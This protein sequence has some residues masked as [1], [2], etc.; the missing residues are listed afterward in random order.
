MLNHEGSAALS[1][2][3]PR[4]TGIAQIGELPWGARVCQF[5][6]T[7]EDLLEVHAKYFAA[8]LADHELCIWAVS[9]PLSR[10]AAIKGLSR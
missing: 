2:R 10:E 3:A 5:Y 6:E 4:R 7:A 9:V 1:A 8:G